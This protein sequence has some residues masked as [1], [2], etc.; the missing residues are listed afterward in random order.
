MADPLTAAAESL[1]PP[2]ART[3]F[4]NTAAGPT[5]EAA[6][7]RR[8][9]E[10]TDILTK[11]TDRF[12]Q[13][14]WDRIAKAR[15][16]KTWA[17]EDEDLARRDEGRAR[18][19]EF[20][21]AIGLIDENAPDAEN[22]LNEFLATVP[23]GLYEDDAFRDMVTHKRR[24]LADVRDKKERE[25]YED[26][27][28]GRWDEQDTSRAQGAAAL[29]GATDA[30]MEWAAES[31]DPRVAY[32]Q[33]AGAHER[34]LEA[35]EAAAKQEP[36]TERDARMKRN[37]G[38]K[39]SFPTH[40]DVAVLAG[41][42]NDVDA[43]KDAEPEEFRKADLFDK[44]GVN[45]YYAEVPLAKSADEYVQQIE[46]YWKLLPKEKKPTPAQKEQARK[47][48]R[49]MWHDTMAAR[50]GGQVP[51]AAPPPSTPTGDL[52]EVDVGSLT[53]EQRAEALGT[54]DVPVED[55]PTSRPPG[56]TDDTPT[57]ENEDGQ[58]EYW[59]EGKWQIW[60]G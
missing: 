18:R 45:S 28:R 60:K 24:V 22:M 23:E 10:G 30:E 5:A 32:Y 38:D 1:A 20:L 13:S 12:T 40:V 50:S 9:Q 44:G 8:R 7:A 53:P 35:E 25:L 47:L 17:R 27:L 36:R 43:F 41:G 16:R 2:R 51:T 58:T 31:G 14:R 29:A 21:S 3:S 49:E 33:L 26:R 56:V 4:F 42:H 15:T 59:I 55:E 48:R 54:G 6:A 46:D 52:S 19:G 37:L 39:I 11:A 57:R 34:R